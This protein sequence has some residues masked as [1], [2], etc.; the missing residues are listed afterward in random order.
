LLRGIIYLPNI[1]RALMEASAARRWGML[2]LALRARLGRRSCL[3]APRSN[4]YD[5]VRRWRPQRAGILRAGRFSRVAS[6]PSG[7]TVSNGWD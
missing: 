2:Q 3:A 7:W 4:I 5:L 1:T 6:C